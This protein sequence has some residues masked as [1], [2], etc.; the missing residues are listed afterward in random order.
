MAD[1]ELMVPRFPRGVLL[2]DDIAMPFECPVCH[3]DQTPEFFDLQ[4]SPVLQNTLYATEIDA[5]RA[6]TIDVRFRY[7]AHCHFVFNPDFRELDIVYDPSYRNEQLSSKIYQLYI[8]QTVKWLIEACS[9]DSGGRVLEVAC[10]NGYFLHCIRQERDTVSISGYDP[11]YAGQNHLSGY[12]KSEY[13]ER[14]E[15]EVFDVIIVRHALESMLS[16]DQ[17]MQD[18]VASMHS[19]SKLYVE[20]TDLDY[21]ISSGDTSLLFHEYARYFSLNAIQKIFEKYG[22]LLQD[23][24][25][26]FDRNYLGIIAVKKPR[27]FQMGRIALHLNS[28]V[29]KFERVVIWGISGRA[30]SCLANMSWDKAIVEFGVD[31]DKQKQGQ[32]IPITGQL[33]ISPEEALEYRPGLVIVANANYL[34]EIRS[35]FGTHTGYLT[36]SGDFYGRNPS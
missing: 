16:F 25:P 4:N 10:G 2:K 5:K 31:L 19:D 27:V 33:I 17:V 20:I 32:F 26:L 3:S 35:G 11:A 8:D 15:G 7:C 34:D 36:L 29:T 21:I 22:L 1:H 24:K 28:I 13:Y 23:F 30:V 9:L 18:L 12:V 14:K 6:N